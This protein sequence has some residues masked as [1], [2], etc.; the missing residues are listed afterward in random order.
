MVKAINP[1]GDP[2]IFISRENKYASN[3]KE[4]EIASCSSKGNGK[5]NSIFNKICVLLINL[6]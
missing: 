2:N 3:E 5:N 6:N 1:G 4:G